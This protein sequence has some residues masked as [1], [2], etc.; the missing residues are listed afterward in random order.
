MCHEVLHRPSLE[1]LLAQGSGSND[2]FIDRAAA[3]HT[4]ADQV[5]KVASRAGVK[6]LVLTHF[7]PPV[8]D[9]DALYRDIAADFHGEIVL[10][11]DLTRAY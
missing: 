6:K 3:I 2:G 9:A 1:R 7:I 11:D 10:A 8:F 4:T 5:G